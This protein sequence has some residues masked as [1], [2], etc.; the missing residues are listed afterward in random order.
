MAAAAIP[1]LNF[2]PEVTYILAAILIITGLALAFYGHGLWTTVMSMIGALLG[3]AVGFLFGAALGGVVAGL[4]LAL[5]GAVIGSILFT[6]LVKVALAF[7]VGLL[8]AAL[9]YG[10]LRGSANFTGQMDPPLVGAILVLIV[11]FGISYYFIDD[12]IGII[13]A[14]IGGLLLALGLYLL[15]NTIVTPGLAG[16]GVF[17]LGA[18]VQTATIKKKQRARTRAAATPPPPTPPPM[19]QANMDLREGSRTRRGSMA[20][21]SS[22]R[23][24][25]HGRLR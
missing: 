25:A 5:V 23:A 22:S 17:L 13:T 11:V 9:V 10:L 7:L 19:E 15:T 3:S 24:F 21:D 16:L 14:A 4:V 1:G 18:L 8:A 20:S 12:I 2:G 6:K